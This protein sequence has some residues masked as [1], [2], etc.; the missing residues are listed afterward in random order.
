M[1]RQITKQ[2]E[3]RECICNLRIRSSFTLRPL[4]SQEQFCSVDTAT[5]RLAV[6]ITVS[7]ATEGVVGECLDTGQRVAILDNIH[8]WYSSPTIA[9]M[10]N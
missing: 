3:L 5:R 10:S 8:G 2:Y 1:M 6:C 7:V 4:Y 9:K